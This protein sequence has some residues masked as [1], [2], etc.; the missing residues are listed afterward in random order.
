MNCHPLFAEAAALVARENDD[1]PTPYR[2][3]SL[4]F[5]NAKVFAYLN[6]TSDRSY[7]FTEWEDDDGKRHILWRKMLPCEAAKYINSLSH[8]EGFDPADT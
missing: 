4:A 1:F 3:F 7:R 6:F 5:E 2:N 8:G